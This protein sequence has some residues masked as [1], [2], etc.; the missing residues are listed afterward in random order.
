MWDT[1]CALE[2]WLMACS[3]PVVAIA[4]MEQ[5]R[6]GAVPS[7]CLKVRPVI[8]FLF[9]SY[10]AWL[11]SIITGAAVVQHTRCMK[12]NHSIFHKMNE[13]F[14]NSY[15][16]FQAPKLLFYIHICEYLN[17]NLDMGKWIYMYIK[18][19]FYILNLFLIREFFCPVS[20]S[21]FRCK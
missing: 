8:K 18:Y 5:G 1:Q 3:H 20:S 15:R 4:M 19:F 6:K 16:N 14:A 10:F 9:N 17:K 12:I 13:I 2:L 11:H 7:D 21:G